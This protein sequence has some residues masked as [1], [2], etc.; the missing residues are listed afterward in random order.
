MQIKYLSFFLVSLFFIACNKEKIAERKERNAEKKERKE[1]EGLLE[2]H[3]YND[4]DRSQNIT[5]IKISLFDRNYIAS[6]T[7]LI[8]DV[9]PGEEKTFIYDCRGKIENG[10]DYKF[11]LQYKLDSLDT[12]VKY[13]Y[14]YGAEM[15]KIDVKGII[16]NVYK[17]STSCEYI[18][19]KYY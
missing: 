10:V 14:F 9:I 5:D 6:N 11:E 13:K 18:S 8:S 7:Q 15:G 16:F 19:W 4:N 2:V 17:Y 3:I 12:V 1:K